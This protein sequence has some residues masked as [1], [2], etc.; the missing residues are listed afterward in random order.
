MRGRGS[1]QEPEATR[2]CGRSQ[3][4]EATRG[5]GR[6][7]GARE[8]ASRVPPLSSVRSQRNRH[9]PLE[10]RPTGSRPGALQ[11][12]R[13]GAEAHRIRGLELLGMAT[14]TAEAAHGYVGQEGSV[15]G[16]IPAAPLERVGQRRLEGGQ[17]RRSGPGA[18]RPRPGGA[19]P[20]A[21]GAH[22]A[23]DRRP[24]ASCTDRQ[25]AAIASMS[26]TRWGPR[27]HS[28]TCSAVGS[29]RRSPWSA[30]PRPSPEPRPSPSRSPGPLAKRAPPRTALPP[31]A[32][33]HLPS[34]Q[35]PR[36]RPRRAPAR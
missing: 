3:E 9:Q 12:H 1:S 34:G 10:A 26:C 24:P 36:A 27:K 32:G 33:A 22:P 7:P 17:M 5:C 20:G 8:P 11:G 14:G 4:P 15:L 23:A 13:G 6:P 16:L 31:L 2:G 19:G 25:A 30:K 28:V 29:R 21:R 35:A 18:P